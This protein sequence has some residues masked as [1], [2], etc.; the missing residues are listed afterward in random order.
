[1]I[2][3]EAHAAYEDGCPA[4]SNQCR[5]L[6]QGPGDVPLAIK[7][8]SASGCIGRWLQSHSAV[9]RASFTRTGGAPAE[10]AGGGRQSGFGAVGGL[11]TNAGQAE[12]RE[13]RWP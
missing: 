11:P 13:R 2:T 5:V 7:A 10:R 12:A 8:Q 3:P 1:M 9:A 4:C 6:I